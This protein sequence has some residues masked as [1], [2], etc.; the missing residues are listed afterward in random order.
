MLKF[1]QA[2]YSL[3]GMAKEMGLNVSSL[4]LMLSGQR[5]MKIE[6]ALFLASFL[7]LELREILKRA[8][9]DLSGVKL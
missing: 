6:E 2:G 9:F 5:Q 7:D 3:R 4:S 8:G 1:D